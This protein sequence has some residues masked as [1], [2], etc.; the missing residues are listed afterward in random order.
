MVSSTITR[1]KQSVF[2]K[3]VSLPDNMAASH[4]ESIQVIQAFVE[5]Q[6]MIRRVATRLSAYT[7]KGQK[8]AES[9]K[10]E[11]NL[12]LRKHRMDL[13]KFVD[14]FIEANNADVSEL[15]DSESLKKLMFARLAK[16]CEE[17]YT[18]SLTSEDQAEIKNY[19][20]KAEEAGKDLDSISRLLG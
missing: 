12:A 11:D 4:P 6:K 3:V 14:N 15:T 2:S 20:K 10:I 16:A 17:Y 18:V 7:V 13:E 1:E 19:K 5:Q 8:L 9:E